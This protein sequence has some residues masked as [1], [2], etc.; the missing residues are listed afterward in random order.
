MVS[1]VRVRQWSGEE[2]EGRPCRAHIREEAAK[3]CNRS[4][5]PRPGKARGP[6]AGAG[7]G[8]REAAPEPSAFLSPS[9]GRRRRREGSNFPRRLWAGE[10]RGADENTHQKMVANFM[11]LQ[12]SVKSS[13]RTLSV[14]WKRLSS[15]SQSACRPGGAPMPASPHTA[16]GPAA[17]SPRKPAPTPRPLRRDA[18]RSVTCYPASSAPPPAGAARS[19]WCFLRVR[20]A[21][22]L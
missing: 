13:K 18:T 21:V 19:A 16:S 15:A 5:R 10:G 14:S 7:P 9:P 8:A 12:S 22:L 20:G 3:G 2:R 11:L 4:H 1:Q 17:A 6:G